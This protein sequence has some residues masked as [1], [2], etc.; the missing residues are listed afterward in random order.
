MSTQVRLLAVISILT[1]AMANLPLDVA[2]N[3][4]APE[5]AKQQWLPMTLPPELQVP[6]GDG[7]EDRL[8]PPKVFYLD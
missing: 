1:F 6:A 8:D 7:T 2:G 3:P 4:V 5:S